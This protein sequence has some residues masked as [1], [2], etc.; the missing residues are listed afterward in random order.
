[1][2]TCLR[3]IIIEDESLL[4]MCVEDMLIEEGIEVVGTA[5]D[6]NGALALAQSADVDFAVLDAHIIGGDVGPVFNTLSA[7]SIPVLFSTG[8][9]PDT[10]RDKYG[11]VPVLSKPYVVD[12]LHAALARVINR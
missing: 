3:A 6:V 5:A 11:D 10:I 4:L 2:S 8:A 12:E 1:M 7:R 9:S